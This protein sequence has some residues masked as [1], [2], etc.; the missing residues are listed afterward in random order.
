MSWAEAIKIKRYIGNTGRVVHV[1]DAPTARQPHRNTSQNIG[2]QKN[3]HKTV[4]HSEP[5]KKP[6]AGIDLAGMLNSLKSLLPKGTD[7]GDILVLAVF[8]F[9]YIESR[10]TDFLII[11]AVLAFSFF[12]DTQLLSGLSSLLQ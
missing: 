1:N 9:L 12:K 3:E 2:S 7:F 11:L 4:S 10:D 6:E 8:L 5:E